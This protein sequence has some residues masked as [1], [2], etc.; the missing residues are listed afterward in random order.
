MPNLIIRFV[1]TRSLVGWLIRFATM[2]LWEHCE[3]LSRDGTGW[4][5]AHTWTGVEQRPLD[6][7]KHVIEDRRY[8]IPV[9]EAQF[10]AAHDWLEGKLGTPY[11]Y[12][13]IAGIALHWRWL[14]CRFPNRVDCSEL[15]TGF[16]QQAGFQPLNTLAA[17]DAMIS[18]ETLHLSSLFIDRQLASG[19]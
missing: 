18:P 16:L 1:A 15:V 8:Q 13:V 4:V 11:N 9:T 2:S 7:D 14:C 3:V 6:W 19:R 5:G 10:K 17:Y 12:G